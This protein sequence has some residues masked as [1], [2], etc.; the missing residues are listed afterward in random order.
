MKK[1]K[2]TRLKAKGTSKRD[3]IEKPKGTRS[4]GQD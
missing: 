2:G 3:K 4:K 1:G